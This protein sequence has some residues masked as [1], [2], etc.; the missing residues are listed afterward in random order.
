MSLSGKLFLAF[1]LSGGLLV[2]GGCHRSHA[3]T[4][5][6]ASKAELPKVA[7]VRTER[8]NLVQ[9]TVQP[10]KVEAF[11]T[12][13]IFAKVSGYIDQIHVD[14]GDR[15][16]GPKLD[17]TG[18]TVEPGQL[19]V[20]LSAPEVEEERHQKEATVELVAA[21]VE[22]SEVAVKM[23]QT[24]EE[25]AAAAIEECYAGLERADA[26]LNRWRSEFDRIR[27]LTDKKTVTQKLADETEEQF[28]SA[29]AARNEALAKTRAAK[30]RR[31]EVLV[32]IEKARADLK[33]VQ[34]RLN[35]ARADRDRAAALCEYLEVR[36]PIPGI[37]TARNIDR[38]VLVQAAKSM[39]EA[40]LF[41]IVQAD[42]VRLFLDVPESE[43][44]L[45]E[46]E[47]HVNVRVPAA[48][49]KPFTGTVAR[50]GWALQTGTRTLNCE[51][52]IPNPDGLLRPGM[53]AQVELVVAQRSEAMALPKSA[54]IIVDGQTT[55]LTVSKERV[56]E[57]KPVQ[58]G[59]RTDTEIEIVSGLDGSE[60]V[61]SANVA[62][63]RAG[64]QVERSS[65]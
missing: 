36:A 61:I 35:V 1:G 31:Q 16:R 14:I 37:V 15:V 55:C 34:A 17:E 28:K 46:P 6:E 7:T 45:V 39:N 57:A 56:I 33:T 49:M 44:V 41:T 4:S 54:V 5:S 63:F 47:R 27:E 48:G 38:G 58:V 3:V 21:E 62:A 9:K 42:V 64:Q 30:A 25:S 43:A 22:Q 32:A 18:K 13:P 23:S 11:H 26:N 60:D 40:P 29:Q 24:S 50:T 59:I 52:D 65:P 53:Y 12:A 2:V 51:I 19:L 20:K 8:K 10:G